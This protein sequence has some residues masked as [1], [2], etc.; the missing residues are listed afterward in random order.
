[1]EGEER[2]LTEFVC[3]Q[4]TCGTE[5]QVDWILRVSFQVGLS[6]QQ[7]QGRNAGGSVG[8]CVGLALDLR[9]SAMQEGWDRLVPPRSSGRR[10]EG[11]GSQC[12]GTSLTTFPGHKQVAGW[13]AGLPGF[14]LM[15]K[16][17][18]ARSRREL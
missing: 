16:T 8:Q 1:M 12:F 6:L 7:G 5:V 15:P 11:G 4:A 13:K 18:P 10:M 2:V 9:E 3:L 14:E 17:V